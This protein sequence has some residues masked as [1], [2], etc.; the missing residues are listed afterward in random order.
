[1][2]IGSTTALIYFSSIF[3]F[4]NIIKLS[5]NIAL[6]IGYFISIIYHFTMNKFLVFKEKS[7][8]KVK[9]QFPLYIILVIIN[10]IINLVIVNILN[11][12]SINIYIGVSLATLVTLLNTFFVMNKII[13]FKKKI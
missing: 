3:L 6:T 13:F 12:F 10:Y 7:I 9:I 5:D 11:I 2:I 1:M 8:D 4:K